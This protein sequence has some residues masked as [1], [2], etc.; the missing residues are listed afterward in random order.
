MSVSDLLQLL[1]HRSA[2]AVIAFMFGMLAILAI[3]FYSFAVL[4]GYQKERMAMIER[5]IHLDHPDMTEDD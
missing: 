4:R 1:Q 3:L 2:I 5:G